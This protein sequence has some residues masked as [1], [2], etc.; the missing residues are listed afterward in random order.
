MIRLNSKK[1][2]NHA[3]LSDEQ[4]SSAA[5]WLETM[6]ADIPYIDEDSQGE[7]EEHNQKENTILNIKELYAYEESTIEKENERIQE[8]LSKP[9][10]VDKPPDTRT[11]ILKKIFDR[12]SSKQSGVEII[13]QKLPSWFCAKKRKQAV[14]DSAVSIIGRTGSI[15]QQAETSG[16]FKPRNSIKKRIIKKLRRSLER[17]G[18]EKMK[19]DKYVE[20]LEKDS[21]STSTIDTIFVVEEG[22]AK[23]R[24]VQRRVSLRKNEMISNQTKLE[25]FKS[26]KKMIPS[27]QRKLSRSISDLGYV[28]IAALKFKKKANLPATKKDMAKDWDRAYEGM[29]HR[30]QKL[31][32]AIEIAEKEDLSVKP[33]NTFGT[34]P[35]KPESTSHSKRDWERL[36]FN[37]GSFFSLC[38]ATSRDTEIWEKSLSRLDLADDA[39]MSCAQG[40]RRRWNQKKS[41][42]IDECQLFDKIEVV[43]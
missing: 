16:A 31:E 18:T 12:G 37:Q 38:S 26:N 43:E 17:H 32:L 21:S 11:T 2:R 42:S 20:D 4:S 14:T 15:V 27:Q 34:Q 40:N 30:A 19:N 29:C 5:Q 33:V 36:C 25:E 22:A 9:S 13:H 3:V 24:E 41:H 23:E 8:E 6:K 39:R 7:V 10:K 28:R 35:T 1:I